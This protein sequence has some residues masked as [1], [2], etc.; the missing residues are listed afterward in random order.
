MDI[1]FYIGF[2]A[3]GKSTLGAADALKTGKR[4]VDLDQA[5]SERT[6]MPTWQFISKNGEKAFRKIERD[7]LH[8]IVEEWIKEGKPAQIVACGGGTPCFFDNLEFMKATGHVVF[9]DTPIETMLERISH[10]PERW[11]L[12]SGSDPRALYLS[13][14]KWYEKAHER[15]VIR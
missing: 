2:M 6:G 1:V 5:I 3:S 10:H 4:F 15:R 11:P 7:L 14:K 13:R 12:A 8:S 9:I